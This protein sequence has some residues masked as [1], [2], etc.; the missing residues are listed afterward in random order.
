MWGDGKQ[1]RLF[2]YIDECLE[3]VHRF[4][5]SDFMG[6]V[7]ISQDEMVSIN[8]LV[9][10]ARDIPG[11]K[12]IIKHIPD[13]LGVR[14]RNSDNILI[15]KKLRWAP[16]ESLYDGLQKTY[17]WIVDQVELKNSIKV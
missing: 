17:I 15:K 5:E 12:Q 2:L 7:N 4:M 10:M 16:S 14:D 9:E 13:S 11:I 6:P 3:G 1:T 8:T